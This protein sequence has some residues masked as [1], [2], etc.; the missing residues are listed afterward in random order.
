MVAARDVALPCLASVKVLLVSVSGSIASENVAST[1]RETA[2]SAAPS[3]G[4]TLVS[5][6]G[7]RSA[8]AVAKDQPLSA[9][10]GLPTRSLAPPVPPVTVAVYVVDGSR[11]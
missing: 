9:M 1:L 5:V 11:L 10:S 6:G 8:A 3:A 7:V 2:T 4:T